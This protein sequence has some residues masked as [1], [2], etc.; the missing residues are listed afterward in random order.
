LSNL[1][2]GFGTTG[3]MGTGNLEKT[4]QSIGSLNTGFGRE[5][6]R[7]YGTN[8]G[9]GNKSYLGKHSPRSFNN[10]NLNDT[11]SYSMPPQLIGSS[12]LRYKSVT[13]RTS[14]G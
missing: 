11:H 10:T 7:G 12:P 1:N 2:L 4:P 5:N 6:G 8:S 9:N 13:N 14:E 3:M